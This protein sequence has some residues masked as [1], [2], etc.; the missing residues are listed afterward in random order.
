MNVD[1]NAYVYETIV[2]CTT[3]KHELFDKIYNFMLL[4]IYFCN[5]PPR[6]HFHWD[7]DLKL[8]YSKL[9]SSPFI[10]LDSVYMCESAITIGHLQKIISVRLV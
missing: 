1:W 4:Q 9:E 3:R 5:V 7:I 8:G 10:W 6:F 2:V